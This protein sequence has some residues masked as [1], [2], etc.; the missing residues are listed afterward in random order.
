MKTKEIKKNLYWV[1]N[2]D[3]DLR[4]FDIIMETEFGTTYNSYVLKGSEKTVLFESSKLKFL[5]EYL[6]KVESIVSLKELDY[7]VV[8]H[9]EPDHAGAIEK[10][11]EINPGIKIVGTTTA[12]N[13]L[14]EICN[15]DFTAI[16]V[17][18][19]DV[20]SLGDK[21]LK[22][23]TAPNLHWPDTMFTY[24][25]EDKTLVTCDCFG[26]HYSHEGITND[27]IPDQDGYLRALRYYFHM[28]I[29]PFKSFALEAIKK[30]ENL[31]IDVIA[32]GHGPVLVKN[33]WEVVELYKEW[34]TEVNPNTK[35]TVI[36]P[37]VSAYG[38]TLE[39]AEKITDGIKA[40]GDIDVRRYDLVSSDATKVNEEL[41]WADGLLF[42]TPTM[43]GE[44]LKP[45][46]DLCIGWSESDHVLTLCFLILRSRVY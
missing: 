25:P 19:K 29:G 11:L 3:P 10:L 9:T 28:I 27:T 24:V 35:K 36:I 44:A 18:D 13:F 26:S 8:N 15:K 6:E 31:E 32:T 43:V 37:Y 17:S 21:T 23:I 2:L 7:L 12:I 20:L 5:A 34:A 40:A 33:P 39:L 16:T 41:Y 4:I 14:K 46:W 30:I 45:I 1:G 22:F 42:G 38:Y